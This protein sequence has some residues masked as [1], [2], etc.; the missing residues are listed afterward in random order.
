[1][2]P[3]VTRLLVRAAADSGAGAPRRIV[4][5]SRFSTP[6][7]E[8]HLRADGAE[9]LACDLLD[10]DA[11]ARV[12]DAPNVIFLAGQKFGTRQAPSL[13]WAMNV[14]VPTLCAERFRASRIVALSTGNVYPLTRAAAGGSREEDPPA[15][16]GEY[17]MS[18]LGRER[19]FEHAAERWGT[20][21]S[22]LRLNY[23]N[24]LRY[25]VLTDLAVKVW[26][27]E[28]IDLTMGHVNVIWQ[29]DAARVTVR[30]LG[31]AATPAVVLNVTGPETLAVRAL[32]ER[33]GTLLGREPVFAGTE[34][35]DALLS[36]ARRMTQLV[37]EPLLPTDALLTMVAAW[38]RE[39]RPLLG[40][41]TRFEER[42]GA[43]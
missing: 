37:D 23:A 35:A 26:R 32:A 11:L 7:L 38:V 12:P 41:P 5:V 21:V 1:M 42:G 28:P 3:T 29:G 4:A 27:H 30:A 20:P 24:D 13:T 17:A 22:L 16:I 25:G 19:V 34:A 14:M 18:C 43:F 33:L 15:P 40:K 36:N 39:G 8:T 2:G 10:R 31:I 9:T 6:E